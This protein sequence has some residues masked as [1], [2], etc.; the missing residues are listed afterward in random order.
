MLQQLTLMAGIWRA[1]LALPAGELPFNFE[2]KNT[3]KTI[4]EIING[5]ER[6]LVDEVTYHNDSVLIQ[7]PI[8]DATINAQITATGLQGVFT[9]NTRKTNKEIPFSAIY[10]NPNRFVKP[11]IKPTY[12]GGKW[13]VTFSSGLP[14]QS[15][16]IAI[17]NQN[18]GKIT[19][20]FQTPTGDYR[21]LDGMVSGDS[22]WLS[23]FDGSH[24][25]LFTATY[26]DGALRGMF[27]SGNHHSETWV[28]FNNEEAQLPNPY[29]ITYLK[30]GFSI[31]DFS[32][33][34]TAGNTVSL[35]DDYFKNK[36]VIVQLM[37]SWCPNCMDETAYLSPLY[38]AHKQK[39][40]VVGLAFE[41]EG[42]LD[43]QTTQ[44]NRLIKR[45]NITYPVLMAGNASKAAASA[46]L[47]ML[48]GISS[49]PTT[50]V[51]NKKHS[52]AFIHTGFNGPATG[53]VYDLFTQ[54][55]EHKLKQLMAE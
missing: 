36:V 17:F 47:P 55:F 38:I 12:L 52:V 39:I 10:N 6:I 29:N 40:A 34:N 18:Q 9:N 23:C 5:A 45:Y 43:Y 30:P 42:T 53:N 37:G 2:V 11:V 41:K 1:T 24:A 48:N 13:Q 28:A 32:F 50:I 51:L 26:S 16:A 8:F 4:I 46:A 20:T 22:L 44:V 15:S 14:A 19:G 49:F 31:I 25:F 35:S 21:Y 7:L 33:K 54:D 3:D 27:Y